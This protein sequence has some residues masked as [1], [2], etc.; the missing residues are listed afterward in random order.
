[1]FTGASDLLISCE[2]TLPGSPSLIIDMRILVDG[3]VTGSCVG[4][5]RRRN[6]A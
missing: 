4:S 2:T 3:D 1:M 6:G 5:A